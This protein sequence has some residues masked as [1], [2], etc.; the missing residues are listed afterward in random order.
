MKLFNDFINEYFYLSPMHATYVGIHDYD[1]KLVNNY[2]D[3]QIKKYNLFLKKYI[4]LVKE[5]LSKNNTPKNEHYLKVL[6]YRLEMDLE[7]NKYKLHYLPIDSLHNTILDWVEL[8][9]GKSYIKLVNVSDF[10]NF[11][12]RISLYL[13]VIDSMIDRMNDGIYEGMTHPKVI[14]DKV[15]VDLEKVLKNKDY[16]LEEEKIPKIVM[17]DYDL[18]INNLFPKK[19]KKML[20]YLKSTYIKKCHNGFGLLAMKNGKNIYDYLV[21]Y[22]TTLQNPNIPEIHKLGLLEVKRIDINI[23]NLFAK[24]SKIYPNLINP[25]EL[26]N[27]KREN[28]KD[29]RV[30][31]LLFYSDEED[32]IR[33][34]KDLR[35][36]INKTVMKKYFDAPIKINTRYNIKKVPKFLEENNTGAYY[37]RSNIDLSRKGAFFINVA[38]VDEVFKCNSFSLAIHEGNPGHHY[39]TSY[40]NDMKNPLFISFYQ[41]ETS[42]VEGWGLYAEYLGRE[43]LL[44]KEKKI[45]F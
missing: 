32:I 16:L 39:Q 35:E 23:K 12:T 24:Y 41:D 10:N 6:K 28:V 13:E 26:S 1:D 9:T 18:Y 3:K 38:N 19:I 2:E 30:R 8:C 31:D 43:Y 4:K 37:Q 14:I 7:G 22:H 36:S 27:L 21:R 29:K 15:I 5:Q 33:S 42:Y 20:N 11:L 34:F 17:D 45:K 44:E 40:S 25:S